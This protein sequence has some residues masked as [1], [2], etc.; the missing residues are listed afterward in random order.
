MLTRLIDLLT[1]LVGDDMAMILI[2]RNLAASEATDRSAD[3]RQE[4][5]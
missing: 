5:A 4:Q 1:Q 2:E 3:D